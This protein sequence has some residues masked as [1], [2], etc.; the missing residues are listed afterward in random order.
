MRG[1]RR[2]PLYDDR[3]WKQRLSPAGHADFTGV[4]L[5]SDHPA[6][7]GFAP[8]VIWKACG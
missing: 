8:I 4:Q 3:C 2:E 5:Q 6:P 1:W 7:T